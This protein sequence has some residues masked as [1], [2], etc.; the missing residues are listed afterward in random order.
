MSALGWLRAHERKERAA[1]RGMWIVSMGE[2]RL[3]LTSQPGAVTL[4]ANAVAVLQ[5][6]QRLRWLRLEMWESLDVHRSDHHYNIGHD[7]DDERH[8]VGDGE[9][10]ANA[11][12]SA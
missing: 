1:Y 12:L 10:L 11:L 8:P 9:R 5:R 4:P 3:L 7:G 2:A 6:G